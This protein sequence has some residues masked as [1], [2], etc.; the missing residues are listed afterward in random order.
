[1]RSALATLLAIM[2]GCTILNAPD[3]GLVRRDGGPDSG[4]MDGSQD[5][6]DGGAGDAGDAGDAGCDPNQ[7]EICGN[8]MDDDCDG[9]EDCDDFDCAGLAA[10]CTGTGVPLLDENW[11][12]FARW[13]V[14]PEGASAP[15]SERVP[16]STTDDWQLTDF[17]ADAALIHTSCIGMTLGADIRVAFVP[18]AGTGCDACHAAVYLTQSYY[19]VSGGKL[20]EDLVVRMG[21]DGH[22]V[23]TS[24]GVELGRTTEPFPAGRSVDVTVQVRPSLGNRGEPV[25]VATVVARARGEEAVWVVEDAQFQVQ[26]DLERVLPNC[27]DV[28]GLHLAVAGA[29]D[30]VYVRDLE[31]DLQECANPSQFTTRFAEDAT[32]TSE[33]LGL[34]WAEGGIGAPALV[35]TVIPGGGHR[36][37]M[38]VDG[39]NV[40]RQLESITHIGFSVGHSESLVWDTPP[41]WN[42]RE[43]GPKGGANPP[44]CT[45]DSCSG[46]RAVREPS[47]YPLLSADGSLDGLVV[48]YAREHEESASMGARDVYELR[49][50]TV[51]GDNED[52]TLT[53][54]GA[55]TL[56]PADV[57]GC[58]SLRDPA[59]MPDSFDVD[60]GGWWLF[61]TCESASEPDEIRAVHLTRSLGAELDTLRAVLVPSELGAYAS[62]GVRDPALLAAYQDPADGMQ[63]AYRLWFLARDA[64]GTNLTVN[65]AQAQLGMDASPTPPHLPDFEEYSANPLVRSRD[66]PGCGA[67]ECYLTGVAVTRHAEDANVLRFVVARHVNDSTGS[68]YELVPL[69]QFWRSPWD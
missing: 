40:E 19:L 42:T 36:W 18:Q 30:R 2:T 20:L 31:V 16:G 4:T 67:S 12:T 63:A 14:E 56:S 29:G 22:L 10:C 54:T 9:L 25:L 58:D 24:A 46:N 55:A 27:Q 64:A 7:R 32:L 11:S 44:A 35:S 33:S 34:T 5:A 59:L 3:P 43:T 65:M 28:P 6:A 50:E 57:T 45:D 1:M 53:P 62:G 15:G 17:A 23:V 68:R 41:I 38:L 8:G 49:V 66:L 52:T 61:F 13:E 47:A 48:A 69:E 37:D 60:G 21:A 39:T 51:A 26:A